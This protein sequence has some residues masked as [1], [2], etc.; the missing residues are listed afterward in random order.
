MAKW[1]QYNVFIEEDNAHVLLFNTRTGALMRLGSDRQKQIRE[2]SE[3]PH[4]F[5]SFLLKQ[6]FLVGD[7]VDE[8]E[9]IVNTH[10]SA[11][12]NKDRFSATIELTE[13]CNFKCLYCYQTHTPNHMQNQVY[14]NVI[15]YLTKK[16]KNVKHL[17]INWFGGEPLIRL[18][19]LKRM[20]QR[21][22][23]EANIC[24]C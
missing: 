24:G 5:L 18:N 3:M 17:H 1:S 22:Q 20:S 9:L 21:L 14:D 4:D 7:D 19:A 13:A 11:R 23:A 6:G 10:E 12:D 15:R 8:L 2:P 16:I